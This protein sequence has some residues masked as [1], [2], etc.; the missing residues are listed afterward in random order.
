MYDM[1]N[2]LPVPEWQADI[3]NPMSHEHGPEE[4]SLML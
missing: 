3:N 1:S 4:G 2:T